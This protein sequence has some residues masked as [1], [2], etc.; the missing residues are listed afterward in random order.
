[1]ANHIYYNAFVK[2]DSF[3]DI[4][5]NYQD[6]RSSPILE[7]PNDYNL[8]ITK[9]SLPVIFLPLFVFLPDTYRLTL[10]YNNIEYESIVQYI[11]QSELA[12]NDPDYYFV[13]SYDHFVNMVNN[14]FDSAL[15]GLKAMGGT[16]A[17]AGATAP[18]LK[19]NYNTKQFQLWAESAY[20]NN[21]I[22]T[23]I[24]I[25]VST[26]FGKFFQSF[27]LL[28]YVDTTKRYQF[29]IRNTG[30][31]NLVANASPATTYNTY[32]S[33]LNP[34]NVAMTVMEEEYETLNNFNSVQGVVIT[35][36]MP[37]NAE[38]VSSSF[39][40]STSGGNLPN[41]SS[42]SSLKI[43]AE[44]TVG[45]DTFIRG[46][47]LVYLPSAEYRRMDLT[48]TTPLN[49]VDFKIYFYTNDGTFY[50]Y[51]L[52]AYESANV[53]MLFEKKIQD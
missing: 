27:N 8:V 19:Y 49:S 45:Q 7:K 18:R 13:Y 10:S 21:S 3:Q 20:Y 28:E 9:F 40:G 50:P 26:T 52:T 38:S 24:K 16:G 1:M 32:G 34:Y 37:V 25:F 2:N 22:A 44:F 51:R 30:F 31:N 36:S 17:I 23:P 48:S 15:T 46:S 11:S 53:K 33:G 39:T 35:S 12:I 41:Q 42:N 14:T 5:I 29:V 43:I 47:N 6:I 4:F